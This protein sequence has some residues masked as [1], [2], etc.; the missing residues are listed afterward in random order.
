MARVHMGRL[1]KRLVGERLLEFTK[2]GKVETVLRSGEFGVVRGTG[3][4][5]FDA[6]TRSVT[7]HDEKRGDYLTSRKE[8]AGERDTQ[9]RSAKECFFDK[10]K[11][12]YCGDE[13]EG[14]AASAV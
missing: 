1:A 6:R 10:K 9:G 14:L 7:P 11:K 12:G 4:C 5:C 3:G 2:P 8:C 13:E